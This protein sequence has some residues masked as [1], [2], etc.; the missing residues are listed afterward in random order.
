[1]TANLNKSFVLFTALCLSFS[2]LSW[3]A[4]INAPLFLPKAEAA[5]TSSRQSIL[6]MKDIGASRPIELRGV[7]G[8]TY[9]SL[10]VRLDEVATNTPKLHAPI[11]I[12]ARLPADLFTWEVKGVPIDLKYR[13]TPPAE[14]GD[15]S[16]RIE[17]N[18]QFE[19]IVW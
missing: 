5:T 6:T 12:N 14:Q 8:N 3:A 13:Y 15:A 18:D 16:L 17:I 19:V 10:G 9:L 2:S 11:L 4:Q 1:M 7:D